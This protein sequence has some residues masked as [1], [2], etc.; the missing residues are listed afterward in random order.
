MFTVFMIA[1]PRSSASGFVI[2]RLPL[3]Q[4]RH[5]LDSW[6]SREAAFLANNWILL[7]AAFFV[8]FATMFPTLREAVTGERLTVGPPFFNQWMLPIGLVLLF[9]TGVGPLLAWRKSTL[10]NLRD[11]FLW[12]VRRGG[13]HGR[14]PRGHSASRVLDLGPLLRAVR[15]RVRHDRRR[16]SGAARACGRA[17][18]GT[19]LLTALI[20]LVGRSQAP[21]RRLHR[22]P[23]HRADVPRASPARA[24]SSEE[25]VLLKPGPAGRRSGATP[26]GST[27]SSVTDD[28]Q[29]QMVTANVTVLARRQGARRDVARRS[30]SSAS[31]RRS[32]RPRSRIRRGFCRGPLHRA[33]RLRPAGPVGDAARASS[34][35]SSTGSGWA[36]ACWRSAP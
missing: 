28:G 7:F 23:R 5:E 10:S 35:R 29:K 27:R 1:D 11:Q 18:T 24:S 32:R 4:S 16:S 25:Q 8:L 13:R 34:T 9:L 22:P 2:Y 12:P 6:V 31:T 36:S 15:V 19:D 14:R 20:G 17:T 30:G 21:L 3:L 33:G 26:S